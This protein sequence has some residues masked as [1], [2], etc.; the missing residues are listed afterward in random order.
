MKIILFIALWV[1][2]FYVLNAN[3]HRLPERMRVFI[4]WIH[5]QTFELFAILILGF[6]RLISLFRPTQPSSKGSGRPI[7]LVHGYLDGS[8]VWSLFQKRLEKEELGPIYTVDLGH[9]FQGIHTYAKKV[10]K[11]ALR[12]YKETGRSDPMLIGHSMGG[13][14]SAFYAVE[15]APRG[16]SLQIITIGSPLK[17]TVVAHIGVGQSAR[18]MEPDSKLIQELQKKLEA[19]SDIE[20][21]H[22]ATKTDLLVIPYTSAL[23]RNDPLSHYVLEDIGHVSLLLSRRVA[24]EVCRV[25]RTRP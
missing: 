13:I 21:Y 15:L 22:I 12:I 3:S 19:R 10:E 16:N 24:K 6:W 25:Y 20:F 7:L 18:E 11:V 4:R 2:L 23:L 9:P 14:V 17:G 1:G 8:Y 5:S